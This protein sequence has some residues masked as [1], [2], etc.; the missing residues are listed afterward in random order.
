MVKP[1]IPSKVDV[2]VVTYPTVCLKQ[3]MTGNEHAF[4]IMH[5]L[6]HRN[7][8]SMKLLCKNKIQ[9]NDSSSAA[10]FVE[11][12]EGLLWSICEHKRCADNIK[13]I[14]SVKFQSYIR[15]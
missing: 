12:Y 15:Y 11:P 13:H 3:E 4:R 14:P 1:A 7:I 2:G 8:L 9:Y 5:D 10:A 6:Q